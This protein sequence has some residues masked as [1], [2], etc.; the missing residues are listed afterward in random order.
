MLLLRSFLPQMGLLL[1]SAA[2][3]VVLCLF[4]WWKGGQARG[5]AV[6]LLLGAVL[7]AGIMKSTDAR[8]ARV[9]DAYAGQNVLLTAEVESTGKSYGAGRVSAVLMVE[10]VDGRAERFRIECASLPKCSAGDRIRGRFALEL[11]DETQRLT[12]YAD[13]ILLTADYLSGMLRLGQSQSFRARMNRLQT[14]LSRAL[15]RGMAENTGGILAAMVVGDRSHLSSDLRSAYRGAGLSHVLVVSGLHVSILCGLLENLPRRGREKSRAFR[16]ASS[17]LRALFAFLLVG[18]TGMTPSVLRAAV[19][20]WVSAL[21]VWVGG[22]ADTLTSLGVAGVLMCLSNGYAIGDVGFELSF[23]AVAG[24]LAGGECAERGR[25]SWYKRKH[26][27]VKFKLLIR[28]AGGGWDALCVS[29]CASAAT[30]PVLVLRGMSTTVWAIASG[31]LVVWMVEPM[32]TLGLCTAVLGLLTEYLPLLEILRRPVAFCAEGLAWLLNQWAFHVSDLPGAALWFNGPYAAVVCLLLFLLC[33]LAMRRH[34][35]LR[36]ALPIIC[37]TAAF[38]IGA[39]TAFNW[40]VVRVELVGTKIAPAVV[41]SQRD[42]AIVLFRGG[43]STRRAVQSKLEKRGIKSIELVVDLRMQ[44]ESD[45]PFRGKQYI[46]VSHLPDD[47]TRTIA[48]GDMKM[49]LWRSKKG[50]ILRFNIGQTTFITLSGT[51]QPE[52]YIEADWLLASAARPD[53]ILYRRQ[54]A[55]SQNYRWVEKPM[56]NAPPTH[57]EMRVKSLFRAGEVW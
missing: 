42:R 34:I 37:L 10:T 17:V 28:L 46:V 45:C 44:P 8:F 49:V 54:M 7:G 47:T 22:P 38:A 53:H 41:V 14:K 43:A 15:R 55:L 30:F 18:I 23:A 51:V 4:I 12:D 1:P 19:A 24:T 48:C 29:L 36:V 21:G 5:Y 32:L 20:V 2:I 57:Y 33:A 26:R 16:R 40:D 31:V 6:C 9:Q 27:R 13:G 50:C 39:E 11:P 3:F 52:K 35:R 56:Q 25:K